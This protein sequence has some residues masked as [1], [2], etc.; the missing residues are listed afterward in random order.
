MRTNIGFFNIRFFNHWNSWLNLQILIIIF[1][2]N[3][4]FLMKIFILI[5]ILIFHF[6]WL[7]LPHRNLDVNYL[8]IIIDLADKNT[9]FSSIFKSFIK[10][11][12][13]FVYFFNLYVFI[14]QFSFIIFFCIK[15]INIFIWMSSQFWISQNLHL[16]FK[17]I[18]LL[19]TL[20]LSSWA[21]S[22]TLTELLNCWI[23]MLSSLNIIFI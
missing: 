1:K 8:S 23:N 12:A 6:F 3:E 13:V 21:N 16:L 9:V 7:I 15:T 5:I 14:N 19:L 4:I 18:K 22:S 11:I 20:S 17:W 10:F 2:A